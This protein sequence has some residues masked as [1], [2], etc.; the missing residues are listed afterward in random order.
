MVP[1]LVFAY[2]ASCSVF[3]ERNFSYVMPLFLLGVS[4][5]LREFIRIIGKQI[6]S[7]WIL[8][9]SAISIPLLICFY[10]SIYTEYLVFN[11]FSGK[12][13]KMRMELSRKTNSE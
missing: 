3:F 5:G 4:L 2:F 6:K 12:E 9:T 13:M 10:S 7:G 11:I 1:V 8:R